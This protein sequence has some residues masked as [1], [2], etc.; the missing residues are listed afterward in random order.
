MLKRA[1][2]YF[3]NLVLVA[4]GTESGHFGSVAVEEANDF[5]PDGAQLNEVVAG[6]VLYLLPGCL[7]VKRLV[8]TKTV[9]EKD[10]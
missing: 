2:N 9:A 5:Y 6:F 1:D 8:W 10:G 4:V 3:S 7:S